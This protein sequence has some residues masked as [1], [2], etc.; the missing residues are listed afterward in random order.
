[1][2]R[3]VVERTFAAGLG[4]PVSPE[5][6][7]ASRAIYAISQEEGCTWVQSYVSCDKK[8]TFCVYD[9]PNPD[10]IR[11]AAE[12]NAMSVDRITEVRVLDPFFYY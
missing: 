6:D 7:N 9:G 5:G 10:A 11:R 4:M 12:R 8:T 3:Y 1:M 2:P